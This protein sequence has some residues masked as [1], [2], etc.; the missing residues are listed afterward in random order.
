MLE[1][2]GLIQ[3]NLNTFAM[4]YRLVDVFVIQ[5]TI[6]I[7]VFCYQ[8]TYTQNY[9]HLSL[10]ATVGFA[11]SA[12]AIRLY[13]SW[14]AASFKA[15]IFYTMLS[16]LV[17]S[18]LVLAYLFFAKSGIGFSR[19][20]LLSWF[21]GTFLILIGWRYYFAKFLEKIRRK[22]YNTRTVAIVGLTKA[23]K[24]LAQEILDNPDTGFRLEAIYDDRSLDRID[25]QYHEWIDGNVDEGVA[26][27]K[28]SKFDAVYI[29]LPL[30]AEGR[31]K[32]ILYKLGDTTA[33]VQL[34]PDLLTYC[35]MNASMSQI[36]EIQTISVYGN[37]MNGANAF[38][39]RAEDLF[40]SISILCVIAIPLIAIAIGIKFTSKGP[41][42][43]KQYRYGL[44]G[45]KIKVWKFR[46]MTV[47]ENAEVV[48]Q[49]TK[50]DVRITPFG[51]FLRRTSLDELPQFFNVLQGRMS[52][53][54][55]R[56]HAV[57]HNEEYRKNVD[58]YMLRHKVKPG[59][60]GWA[61]V[62]GWRGETDTVEKM[63]MRI[64]YDLEYIRRWSLWMDFKIVL[65]T[66]FRSFNDKNAY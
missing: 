61:Q 48:T 17:A 64:K 40:L 25:S 59:I 11:F 63:D 20:A 16:W 35:L 13:R 27:A 55:P 60:T 47:T 57:A 38:L 19:V 53:V 26:K 12:E 32:D 66:I 7:T 49:A 46:S 51:A 65:F 39:K 6:A 29:A 22:G 8:I 58:Y 37:P 30:T 14:R 41:I 50:N 3:N 9:F 54:G 1:N 43:F 2:K 31:I 24:R 21:I 10:I 34:V 33:N 4:F 62:N 18:V 36:G 56:P 5:L 44:D 23:G 28:N 45:K 15:L 52:V 42:I